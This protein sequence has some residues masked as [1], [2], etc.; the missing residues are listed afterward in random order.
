MRST[1]RHVVHRRD[2]NRVSQSWKPGDV[3][4]PSR[5]T[6]VG[7]VGA[8]QWGKNL[9][10]EF[11]QMAG[12]RLRWI[13][14]RSPGALQQAAL[15]HADIGMTTKHEEMLADDGLQAVVVATDAGSH[16]EIASAALRAEKHV[17]VEKP[18]ALHGHHAQ[19]LCDLAVKRRR[20]LMVGHIMLYHPAVRA[21]RALIAE[22]E[23]GEVRYL[24]A[25]RLNFRASRPQESPW[26]SLAPHDVAL[27]NYLFADPPVAV[28]ATPALLD[29]RS[30]GEAPVVFSTIEY[31][32]G[33]SAQVHVSWLEPRKTRILTV[34]GT[35]RT[36]IV[37]DAAAHST[38]A[39]Y[40]TPQGMNPLSF[41]V[42]VPPG[43]PVIRRGD[44]D[45]FEPL[46]R[47]CADFVE[48]IRTGRPPLADG[49]SGTAVVR[50]LE[51]GAR[52]LSGGGCRVRVAGC[53]GSGG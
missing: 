12:V 2:V 14:D 39:V 28:T 11:S 25:R 22:G 41:A 27:A 52:S 18:L 23:L 13:C 30:E 21:L 38:L 3:L 4:V 49:V 33:R 6:S 35:R 24:Y 16:F 47:E 43:P 48:A 8:G 46:R 42:D 7:V 32:G 31:P 44:N 37:D 19:A 40:D 9:V 20:T 10:R 5:V 51:A 45:R 15:R 36:A 29:S 1:P 34:V 26:W 53:G 50:V 17:F